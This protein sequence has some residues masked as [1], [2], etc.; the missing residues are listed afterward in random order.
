[1]LEPV[2]EVRALSRRRFQR[3]LDRAA[4]CG[5]KHLIESAG[6]CPQAGRFSAAQMRPGMHHDE[7]HVQ[8]RRS[9]DLLHERRYGF[10]A[11]MSVWGGEIDQ[12]TTVSKDR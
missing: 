4:P 11:H 6:H 9:L 1:M 5:P 7:R 8:Y 12:I 2:T 10:G 3:D